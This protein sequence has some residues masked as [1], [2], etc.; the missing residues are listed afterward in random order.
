MLKWLLMGFIFVGISNINKCHIMNNV[1]IIDK[2]YG[3]IFYLNKEKEITAISLN[4]NG[5]RTEEWTAK[6]DMMRDFILKTNI[7]IVVI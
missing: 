7:D 3:D 4:I 5:L 6:N 1:R 2:V